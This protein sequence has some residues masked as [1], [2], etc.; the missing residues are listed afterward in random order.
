MDFS[1]QKLGNYGSFYPCLFLFHYYLNTCLSFLD[2]TV[3]CGG[4]APF[5]LRVRR[6]Y[7]YFSSLMALQLCWVIT[8][9]IRS[10]LQATVDEICMSVLGLLMSNLK[11]PINDQLLFRMM[12]LFGFSDNLAYLLVP[13]IDEF[14]STQLIS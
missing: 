12:G 13:I 14:L 10:Y 8:P 11:K 3:R 5:M 9:I 4:A 2:S 6:R 7:R 1:L